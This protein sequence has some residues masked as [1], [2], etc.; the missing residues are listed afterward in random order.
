MKKFQLILLFFQ[1]SEIQKPIYLFLKQLKKKNN[2][3]VY[4]T[5]KIKLLLSNVLLKCK[6]IHIYM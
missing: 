3:N 1:Y 6:Y 2:N 4:A 5:N